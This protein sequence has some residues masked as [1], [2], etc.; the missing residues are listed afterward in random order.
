MDNVLNV[1]IF[2]A[3][4][5]TFLNI[6]L[7]KF[8]VPTII[9]YIL[10]GLIISIIFNLKSSYDTLT[11]IA[12]F[13][14]VFL[15]FTIGLEFS[16]SHLKTM[17]KEVFFNGILQV[18]LTTL[19]FYTLAHYLFGVEQKASIV[20]GS[21]LALS[22]TAIV[23]KIFNE[24]GDINSGYGRKALGVLLFQDIAVI[25][26][27]LMI[28]IFSNSSDS[29]NDLLVD[30]FISA[31]IALTLLVIIGK[32]LIGK[33]LNI[34]SSTGSSAIFI[35]AILI[36]V[37]GSSTL[38]HMFG[39]SYSLGAFIAGMMLAETKYKYQIEADLVPFRDLLLGLFFIT[40]GMQIDL[41]IVRDYI[42]EIF[43]L[44]VLILI[45]KI[46]ILFLI[47][48]LTS[49]NRTALK[50]AIA[51]AQVGEF[52]LAVFELAR[53]NHLVDNTQNQ[54]LIVSVVLT[55]ILTPFILRN[56]GQIVDLLMKDVSTDDITIKSAGLNNHIIVCGYG[57]LGK[58]ICSKLRS[59][60]IQHVVIEHDMKLV[61]MGRLAGELIYFGNAT[62][63][64][65]LEHLNVSNSIAT[66]VAIENDHK[67]RLVCETINSINQY[68][69][70]VVKVK[71][72]TE[73]EI[74]KDLNIKHI[75]NSSE[76]ISQILID[77]ALTCNM[78]IR[79]KD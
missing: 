70:V 44:V 77:E 69:N 46:V 60:D 9:G 37:I 47:L 2:T 78:P 12:E 66:I 30:T 18:L 73:K 51:I 29:I 59:M 65:V 67:M 23:L 20:I 52:A 15:M 27:L 79:K 3:I 74:L 22:S 71:D 36:I 31:I 64:N 34:V 76:Q 14:V 57:P 58:Q 61:E 72:D 63:K 43:G 42:L 21:A 49:Q 53:A 6:F 45:V 13:G 62:R 24:S 33:F 4:I 25:P 1:V 7:K 10:T 35:D 55:M 5:S 16:L 19:A 54:I 17:K 38:A 40:V 68:I 48:K 26:I 11:H 75:V 28:T 32:F 8:K 41:H 39:F 56:L 50:T